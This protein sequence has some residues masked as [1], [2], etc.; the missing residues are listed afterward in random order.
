M[1]PTKK[2]KTS[3]SSLRN[4]TLE[5]SEDYWYRKKKGVL[6]GSAHETVTAVGLLSSRKATEAVHFILHKRFILVYLQ[7][8][9]LVLVNFLGLVFTLFIEPVFC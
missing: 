7:L 5:Y 9:E 4:V 1:K 2:E 6:C 8:S 3:T